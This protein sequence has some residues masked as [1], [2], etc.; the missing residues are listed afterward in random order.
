MSLTSSDRFTS[1]VADYV[2]YRP[3]YPVA[4]TDM[5]LSELSLAAGATVADIGAGTGLLTLPLVR[6]GAN[7]IAIDP[8]ED[9]LTAARD[10]LGD[11]RNVQILVGSAEATGLP[12]Q[13][14][15]AI[16]AGQAFHWFDHV[17]S[18]DEFRRILKP[19]GKVVLIWNAKAFGASAFLAGYER[20]LEACVPE[21]SQVRH[22]KSG[23]AEIIAFFGHEPDQHSFPHEQR[24]DWHGV[25]GRVMSS[26][27]APRPGHPDHDT[28]VRELRSLFEEHAQDSMIVWPYTTMLYIGE[29][30]P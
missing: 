28:L 1:R 22:E 13:S 7:V 17:R 30:R 21:F 8:N 18:R 14:V 2:S 16:T 23:D 4:A 12:D 11:H 24:F 15:D 19:D 27:Y 25:L 6:T 26:S 29:L 20:I 5:L 10:Y 9:M 3:D